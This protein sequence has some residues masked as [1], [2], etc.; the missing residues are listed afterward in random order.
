MVN[1]IIWQMLTFTDEPRWSS[2]WV[3][4]SM[5]WRA[6]WWV[7][8]KL[9]SLLQEVPGL[10]STSWVS[11]TAVAHIPVFD[12]YRRRTSLCH[13]YVPSGGSAPLRMSIRLCGT[14]C[15]RT[16]VLS[17]IL[18]LSENDSRLTFIVWLSVS[19]DDTDDSVSKQASVF[20]RCRISEVTEHRVHSSRKVSLQLSS[21]L[22]VGDVWIAQLD[23]KRYPQARSSGYTYN[24]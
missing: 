2:R 12:L 23:R 7:Q 3:L 17:L 13:G 19:A 5:S 20:L 15:W 18:D 1:W 10:F 8:F 9:S 11:S 14:R 4:V 16:Y 24:L 6:S 21:E 22:S